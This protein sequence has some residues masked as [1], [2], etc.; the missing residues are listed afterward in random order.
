MN[1]HS[2]FLTILLIL[3]VASIPC[4]SQ[5][6]SLNSGQLIDIPAAKL[7]PPGDVSMELRMYP[8]GGLLTG[9]SIGLSERFGMGAGFGG[10]NIIGT[11]KIRMNPQPSVHLEYLLFEELFLSPA[12]LLGF[13]SQG[14]GHWDKQFKRYTVKSRGLYAAASKNTSF[15]GGIGLH[16][17]VNWSLE[18]EDGDKDPNAFFGVHKWINP[19]L[20]L[21][22]EYDTAVNDNS[23]NAVGSGKG[24]LNAGLRLSIL[25]RFWFEI[26]WRNILENGDRVAGST[27]EVKFMYFVHP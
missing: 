16:A 14:F 15:L 9:I 6:G 13:N 23:D 2:L 4:I 19:G 10:E 20:V 27:R 8:N 7:L 22:G 5:P 17:G 12:V 26:D 25:D 1:K 3:G 24:Y 11:G 21:L 18:N